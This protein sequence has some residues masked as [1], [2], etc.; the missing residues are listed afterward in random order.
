MK[1]VLNK[2]KGSTLNHPA[3][4]G[5]QLEGGT[6]VEV[7]DSVAIQVKGIY[8]VVIFDIVKKKGEE[9]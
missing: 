6:A 9:G 7:E 3:L 4:P 8:N 1:F 5:G 2:Q